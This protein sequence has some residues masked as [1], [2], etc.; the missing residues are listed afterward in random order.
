MK[1]AIQ[2]KRVSLGIILTI[3]FSCSTTTDIS[4]EKNVIA[5]I[6]GIWI[7]CEN[8]GN[9]YRHVKLNLDNDMFEAWVQTSDSQNEPIW[10]KLPDEKGSIT[11][12][13]LQKDPEK[14]IRFRKFAF[15]CS[16]RCCGDKSF[17][18]KEISSLISYDEGKGLTMAHK[19]KMLKK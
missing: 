8:I 3:L 1:N 6:Q 15:T 2:L 10:A 13:S 18:I 14:N 12:N 16:G 11:L 7:G 4:N 5:D 19:I 9:M 17:S